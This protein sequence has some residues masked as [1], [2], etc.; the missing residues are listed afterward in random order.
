M[1]TKK[2]CPN[3]GAMLRKYAGQWNKGRKL[4]RP[5]YM[6]SKCLKKFKK[7]QIEGEGS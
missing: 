4:Y 5:Y 2:K 6:C 3:C 1:K 7:A